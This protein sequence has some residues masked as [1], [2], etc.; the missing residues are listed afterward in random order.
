MDRHAVKPEEATGLTIRI[1]EQPGF[2]IAMALGQVIPITP[3]TR[4]AAID[5]RTGTYELREDG[6]YYWRGWDDA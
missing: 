1:Q 6:D 3:T 4:V 5:G 2:N